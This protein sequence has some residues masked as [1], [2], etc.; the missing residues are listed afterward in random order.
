MRKRRRFDEGDDDARRDALIQK[1]AKAGVDSTVLDD[2]PTEALV[3]WLESLGEDADDMDEGE[4]GYEPRLQARGDG[5]RSFNERQRKAWAKQTFERF[6]EDFKKTGVS[7]ETLES[8]AVKATDDQF[9][10]LRRGYK[11]VPSSA[12]R[13]R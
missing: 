5:A 9:E 1:L 6:S 4:G 10:D 11:S 12:R 7:R 2:C 13:R 3:A 8:V